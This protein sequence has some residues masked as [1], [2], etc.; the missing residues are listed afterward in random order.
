MKPC[1][2]C[3]EIPCAH[4]GMCWGKIYWEGKPLKQGDRKTV[5]EV[6]ECGHVERC[7]RW[8]KQDRNMVR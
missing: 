1:D 5:A 4:A 2:H 7:R 3:P 8:Y 6:E